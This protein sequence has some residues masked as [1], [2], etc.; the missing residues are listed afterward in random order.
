MTITELRALL[1]SFVVGRE[2]RLSHDIPRSTL[3]YELLV[4]GEPT[5][6]PQTLAESLTNRAAAPLICAAVNHLDALIRVAEYAEAYRVA[7]SAAGPDGK[8]PAVAAY[9]DLL[10]AL[11]TLTRP[12]SP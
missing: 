12:E 11:S 4:D 10:A 3:F 1:R 6:V 5:T 8:I 2:F 7:S 9:R